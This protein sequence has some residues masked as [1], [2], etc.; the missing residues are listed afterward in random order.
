MAH[1]Q[2]LCSLESL[3]CGS[4]VSV[5][6]YVDMCNQMADEPYLKSAHWGVEKFS[7]CLKRD[8]I[9]FRLSAIFV[10]T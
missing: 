3:E 9:G 6:A 10:F 2:Q 5:T 1:I 7:E 8:E 4:V